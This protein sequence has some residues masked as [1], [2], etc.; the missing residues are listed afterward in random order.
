[1]T[2][3]ILYIA[4]Y[5]APYSFTPA[6]R[7]VE[8]AKRLKEY[9]Y[10]IYVVN[11]NNDKRY[12]KD[13]HTLLDVMSPLIKIIYIN[14]FTLPLKG[15]EY[16]LKKISSKFD[17][18]T[19]SF[20]FHWIPFNFLKI[21]K[22]IKKNNI[23]LIYTTAP[24]YFSLFI[25]YILKKVFKIPLVIEYRDPWTFNPYTI[26]TSSNL[27]KRI[28]GKIEKSI[29]KSSDAI[30]TVSEA[31]NTFLIKYFPSVISE[32]KITVIPSGLSL[33]DSSQYRSSEGKANEIVFTFTG[34]LYG[35][36]DIT[37]L[38]EIVS[39]VKKMGLLTDISLKVNIFGKYDYDYLS[40]LIKAHDLG[41]I[42]HLGGYLSHS[43]CYTQLSS[44]T[45]PLHI[46]ENLNYPTISFKVWEY[47][48][49]R[50]KVLYLGRDDSFTAQFLKKNDLGYTIPINNQ[51][52]GVKR[53]I[54]LIEGIKNNSLHLEVQAEQLKEFTW[55][56]IVQNLNSVFEKVI[57]KDMHG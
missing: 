4:H 55:E 39:N 48:A 15:I 53:L 13:Y 36:R 49:M 5:F 35:L 16:L 57:Q 42:F 30:V 26:N 2:T 8:I 19:P 14:D 7:A 31:L 40:E 6:I 33:N 23:K 3:E 21:R 18:F 9:G 27:Y 25:G 17:F 29:I 51:E 47:L 1:M 10:K 54:E 50:K 46:G 28:Y 44:A 56:K 32:D 24:P 52:L 20:V 45:L 37:P 41:H 11:V 12:P 22:L 43:E 38:I 34:F